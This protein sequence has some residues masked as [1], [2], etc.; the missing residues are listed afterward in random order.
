MEDVGVPGVG[1]VGG[2]GQGPS[3]NSPSWPEGHFGM[4]YVNISQ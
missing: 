3:P 2:R 4:K 1:V